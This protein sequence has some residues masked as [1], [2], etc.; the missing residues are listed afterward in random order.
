MHLRLDHRHGELRPRFERIVAL[1][2]FDLYEVA[3]D[4]KRWTAARCA[5]MPRLALPLRSFDTRK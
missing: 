4:L 2:R 1:A 3:G 5:S